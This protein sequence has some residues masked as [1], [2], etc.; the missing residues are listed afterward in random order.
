LRLKI[1]IILPFHFVAVYRKWL[2]FTNKYDLRPRASS[3]SA[4]ERSLWPATH[5]ESSTIE[6]AGPA[7][8]Q[9][10][11]SLTEIVLGETLSPQTGSLWNEVVDVS[12]DGQALSLPSSIEASQVLATVNTE[13]F[14][15]S[16]PQGSIE[17]QLHP[18]DGDTTST[19]QPPHPHPDLSHAYIHAYIHRLMDRIGQSQRR[20]VYFGS[21][22]NWRI[23]TSTGEKVQEQDRVIE[24]TAKI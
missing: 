12:Q 1:K 4:T 23:D 19:T 7:S 10:G 5:T 20:R 8:T 6:Q 3:V 22:K 18:S 17:E 11:D 24:T 2:C 13:D 9:V 21:D 15:S 14:S 16:T